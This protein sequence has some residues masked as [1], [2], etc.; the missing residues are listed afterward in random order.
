LA[1]VGPG[2]IDT[3]KLS[4]IHSLIRLLMFK[5]GIELVCSNVQ[6]ILEGRSLCQQDPDADENDEPL[7]DSAEFDAVLISAASDV[8][9][10]LSSVLG[11][12]FSRVF[13]TFLPL[14]AKYTVSSL[15]R[16]S[17]FSY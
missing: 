10:S 14:I 9:A 8:V 4:D 5:I 11:D 16:T 2:L 13:G 3:R 12:D 6:A 15:S 7:E 1:K 17:W